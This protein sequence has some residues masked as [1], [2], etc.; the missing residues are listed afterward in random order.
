MNKETTSKAII[1][2]K[3]LVALAVLSA[4]IYWVTGLSSPTKNYVSMPTLIQEAEKISPPPNAA[5][6]EKADNHKTSAALVSSRYK[7]SLSP[8]Q[9]FEHYRSNLAQAGWRHTKSSNSLIDE[10][11]KG[12][13][14][15]EIEFN[16]SMQF[17]TFSII[18]R[19]RVTTECES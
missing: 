3:A 14:R 17:Y 15:A 8:G 5:L 19:L 2:A 9:V 16:P 12:A 4:A 7:T 10:Y 18:W 13:L 11:C 1:G 6:I